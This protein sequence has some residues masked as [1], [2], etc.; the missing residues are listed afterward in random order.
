MLFRCLLANKV[1]KSQYFPQAN[2]KNITNIKDSA[3]HDSYLLNDVLFFASYIEGIKPDVLNIPSFYK[4]GKFLNKIDVDL[5]TSNGTI[6]ME[7]TF[8]DLLF[9]FNH[10][11]KLIDEHVKHGI[12]FGNHDGTSGYVDDVKFITTTVIYCDIDYFYNCVFAGG[13]TMINSSFME[14]IGC[15]MSHA[16]FRNCVFKEG[17]KFVGCDLTNIMFI[18]CDLSDVVFDHCEINQCEFKNC[19]NFDRVKFVTSKNNVNE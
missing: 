4:N 3:R 17:S 15:S 11:V 10:N 8:G 12:V 18:D 5:P 1:I 16:Q 6:K 2:I 19:R 9:S 14:F 7:L 13:S